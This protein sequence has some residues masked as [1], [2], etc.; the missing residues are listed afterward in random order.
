MGS[1]DSTRAAQARS[2]S[3]PDTSMPSHSAV[4]IVIR[5]S[6]RLGGQS[7]QSTNSRIQL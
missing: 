5:R 3:S 2:S 1:T 6:S 4:F 7:P